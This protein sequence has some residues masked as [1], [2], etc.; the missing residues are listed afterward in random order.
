MSTVAEQ[1]RTARLARN[2]TVEQVAEI[3]KMRTDHVRALEE[4]EYMTFSAP[5]YIRGSVRTYAGLLKLDVPAVMRALE[6]E[7]AADSRFNEA[8]PHQTR[9][10]NVV[11]QI[12]LQLS[13]LDWRKGLVVLLAAII[14]LV[15]VVGYIA[16]HSS[17]ASDPLKDL[18]PGVYKPANEPG[19]STPA[20]A[21]P[22]R[23][24]P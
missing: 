23:K 6:A 10:S 14:L 5:V 19:Q 7:L 2:L 9:S 12:T 13:K 18:E 24:R 17:R 8:L 3:T 1:L 11:D 16:R 4:G 21:H 22:A 15:A 20:P